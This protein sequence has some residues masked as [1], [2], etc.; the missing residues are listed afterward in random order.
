MPDKI[1]R[2]YCG[3]KQKVEKKNKDCSGFNDDLG[4]GDETLILNRS[5]QVCSGFAGKIWGILICFLHS[6]IGK[7]S[8]DSNK[9]HGDNDLLNCFT[10]LVNICPSVSLLR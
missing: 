6:E 10:S 8:G 5:S 1:L 9:Q 2:T 7:G 3:T 4:G